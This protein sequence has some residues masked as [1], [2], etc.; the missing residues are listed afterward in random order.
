MYGYIII[1]RMFLE[2]EQICRDP[3]F[4]AVYAYILSKMCFSDEGVGIWE[5]KQIKLKKGELV[6]SVRKISR[7]TKVPQTNVVR[8]LDF[9]KKW[10]LIGTKS[11]VRQTLVSIDIDAFLKMC[12]GTKSERSWNEVKENQDEK[13]KRNKRE[14]EE[15]AITKKQLMKKRITVSIVILPLTLMSFFK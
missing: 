10:N 1:P 5:K 13:E 2:N 11:S 6:T 9:F 8:I 14:K 4:L 15:I 12:L 7:D 3:Q